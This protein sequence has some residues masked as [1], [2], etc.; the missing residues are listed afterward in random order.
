MVHAYRQ[1]Q[2][3]Q[4]HDGELRAY[5]ERT[6]AAVARQVANDLMAPYDLAPIEYALLKL[7]MEQGECTAIQLAK[8][9]PIDASRISR[10]VNGLVDR[11]LLRRRRSRRDRR[12]VILSLTEEAKDMTSRVMES[13]LIFNATLMDGISEEEKEVFASVAMRILANCAAREDARLR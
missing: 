7:C 13:E 8:V 1:F 5:V 10:I 12:T 6:A 4:V 3:S 9:L 2:N 11:N